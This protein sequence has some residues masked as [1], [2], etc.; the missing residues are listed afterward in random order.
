MIAPHVRITHRDP[1]RSM[2]LRTKRFREVDF[3]LRGERRV[4]LLAG[5]ALNWHQMSTLSGTAPE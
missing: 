3:I 5:V 2:A 4:V 1:L